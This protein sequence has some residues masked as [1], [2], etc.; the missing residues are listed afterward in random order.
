MK[1]SIA[2]LIGFLFILGFA[3]TA[4]AIHAEI[5]AET[6]AV[7]AAGT[8]Q[9]TLSGDLRIRGWLLGNVAGRGGN[10]VKDD[11]DGHYDQRVRLAVDA[12]DGPVT[13][14]I[15][16]ESNTGQSDSWVWGTGLDNKPT[17]MG[18][19]EAWINYAGSGL[20][21]VPS[22]IKVGHM[23]LALGP[24]TLFFDNTKFGDDAIVAYANPT[25]NTHL[26]VLTFKAGENS[27]ATL[28][29]G[30][31]LDVYAGIFNGEFASQELGIYYAYL[32]DPSFG[33]TPPTMAG[34]SELSLQDLGLFG[35][36][37]VAGVDYTAE[38]DFQFGKV[39]GRD[40][41]GYGIWLGLGYKLA[42]VNIRAMFAYGSGDDGSKDKEKGLVTFLNPGAQYYTLVYDYQVVDAGGSI[43]DGIA[44]T[45]VYN[46]GVDIT[47]VDKMKVSLDGYILRANNTETFTFNNGS[48][49]KD[50]GTEVD[51]KGTYQLTKNLTYFANVG[52]LSAGDFYKHQA[53]SEDTTPYVL[54]HG[55]EY[56]F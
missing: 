45:Q 47:P 43:D 14:R 19:L 36:G 42:P 3:A 28:H 6:S 5:P 26:T 17:D 35:K 51:L 11:Q 15:H 4:F 18:I 39:G 53:A 16:L 56:A 22:G 13:G 54:M 38:A 21:G 25:P 10:P 32:N 1:K 33:G 12:A 27:I 46:I 48:A 34:G 23:P 41:S 8:T 31:D 24:A 44:N 9:I 20:L 50:I 37:N 30:N 40:A 29:N 49:S 55:L 7:V 52:V 2:L